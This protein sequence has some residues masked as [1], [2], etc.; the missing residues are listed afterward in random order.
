MPRLEVTGFIKCFVDACDAKDNNRPQLSELIN[1]IQANEVET[2]MLSSLS[3]LSLDIHQCK[4]TLDKMLMY[5]EKVVVTEVN[6][7]IKREDKVSFT[8]DELPF[9]I[10]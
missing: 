1:Y 5:C 3:K 7:Q 8:E 10:N 4:T 9:H 6:L 2:V